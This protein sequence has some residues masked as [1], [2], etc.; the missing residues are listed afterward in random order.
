[1]HGF[2]DGM[3]GIDAQEMAHVCD[4]R[5]GRALDHLFDAAPPASD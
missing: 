5:L 3:F 4:D 2:A 1:V